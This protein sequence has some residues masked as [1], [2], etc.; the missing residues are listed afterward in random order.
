MGQVPPHRDSAIVVRG[1]TG[2]LPP[3]E[4]DRLAREGA[5]PRVPYVA[6]ARALDGDV[7]DAEYVAVRGSYGARLVARRVGMVES[8][9]LEAFHRRR[10]YRHVV[11]W[12]DRIGME[13]ALL[14]K[15]ARARRDL[16]VVSNWLAGDAKRIFLDR[17]RVQSH[18]GAIISYSSVQ[19]R[20]AAERYELSPSKLHLA[21]QPVDERFWE[22]VDAAPSDVISSAGW[23]GRDYPT[24]VEA[25]RG[26]PL[27]LELAV[28]SLILSGAHRR[29]R[30]ELFEGHVGG[31]ANLPANVGVNM[32]LGPVELRDL[33]ARSL[34]VVVPLHDLEYDAGVTTVTE[35]MAMGK[36]VIVSRSRGQVDVIRDGIEGLYVPP[37]DAAAMRSAIE[38]LLARP[39]EAGR[40][41]AAGRRAVLE[42][43]RLDDYVERVATIVRGVESDRRR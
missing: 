1:W 11:A 18:L 38:S 19:L 32:D 15:L 36:A 17:F 43:H 39:D 30:G 3:T 7:I 8:Q 23:E 35:A 40:M 24:L 14:H 27:R 37:G 42:R 4:L 28:G 20:A 22:P 16:V 26:L 33:Y 25:M 34:F 21:L 31:S 9:V 13:L 12:A 29:R 6:L 41:G 5:R 10:T 2:Q